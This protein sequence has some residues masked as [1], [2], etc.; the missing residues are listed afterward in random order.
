[1]SYADEKVE[2]RNY[3]EAGAQCE[4]AR[5]P[6]VHEWN[7]R[8]GVILERAEDRLNE[9]R[10]RL[11]P[12]MQER[13]QGSTGEC[14]PECSIAPLANVLRDHVHTAER[15]EARVIDILASLEI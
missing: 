14:P 10:S 9:L 15:L 2:K 8:L 13:L 12:V 11:S 1:M 7:S 5:P 3:V 6:Q 4:P